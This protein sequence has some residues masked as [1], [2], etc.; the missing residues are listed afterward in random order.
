MARV[1]SD[2]S[3]KSNVVEAHCYVVDKGELI[4]SETFYDQVVIDSVTY[5]LEMKLPFCKSMHK[6]QCF[7]PSELEF[8]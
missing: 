2:K 1:I 5:L 3:V 7:C 4:L 6:A 8:Y